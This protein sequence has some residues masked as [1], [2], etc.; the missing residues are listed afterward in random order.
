M[1]YEIHPDL[2]NVLRRLAKRERAQY[3]ALLKKIE[4]II[5][6][7]N[8][9]HYKNLRKPLQRYRRVHIASDFVLLFSVE[10]DVILFRHYDHHKYVYAFRD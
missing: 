5:Q 9:D 7:P 3:E 2:D 1:K 10:K 8:I 6:N 4:Q